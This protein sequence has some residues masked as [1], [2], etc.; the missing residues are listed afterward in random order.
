MGSFLVNL[1]AMQTSVCVCGGA[2]ILG[3]GE[4]VLGQYAKPLQTH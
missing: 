2:I 3:L 1:E 4:V